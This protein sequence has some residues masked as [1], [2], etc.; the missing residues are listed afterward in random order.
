[1]MGM[2]DGEREIWAELQREA[3]PDIVVLWDKTP[4]A[5]RPHLC[6]ACNEEIAP[7][8]VYE[9]RGWREDGEFKTEKLH[10]W[11]YQHP[12][13]C[14]RFAERDKREAEAAL[15]GGRDDG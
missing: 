3:A 1:M 14:P 11:A 10:R 5:R 8:T 9:S 6:D 4:K 7:G 15:T 13:G 2:S 12:S